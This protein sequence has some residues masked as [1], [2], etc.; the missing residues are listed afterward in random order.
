VLLK[1]KV[2]WV[3]DCVNGQAVTDVSSSS[4]SKHCKKT[5]WPSTLRHH[6]EVFSHQLKT[7]IARDPLT[8]NPTPHVLANVRSSDHFFG[9]SPG[10]KIRDP[11]FDNASINELLDDGVHARDERGTPADDQG[12]VVAHHA[13]FRHH[14]ELPTLNTVRAT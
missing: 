11:L 13:A 5:T 2:F 3:F 7:V 12:S 14:V 1:I 6:P 4:Q 10:S 8:N 9:L